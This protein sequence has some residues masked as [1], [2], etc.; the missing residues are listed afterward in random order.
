[1]CLV[2]VLK[3]SREEAYW[4]KNHNTAPTF[5]DTF[6]GVSVS[7]LAC[8]SLCPPS[9]EIATEMRVA[10]DRG[11]FFSRQ[12]SPLF[13]GDKQETE[14]REAVQYIFLTVVGCV[15]KAVGCYSVSE[16]ETVN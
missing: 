8:E 11:R 3:A 1:M 15:S 14:G 9:M 10:A 7:E 12:L 13:C 6:Y 4:A 16:L 2:L 5:N